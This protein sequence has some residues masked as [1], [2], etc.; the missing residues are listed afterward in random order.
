MSTQVAT[1]N[2]VGPYP[3][4]PVGAGS[5]DLTL[6]AVDSVN[7]NYFIADPV[8]VLPQGSIGGDTLLVYNPTAG[9]LVITFTS[10]PLNG[11]SGDIAAYSV[12]AGVLSAFKFSSFSGWALN[13]TNQVFFTGAAGLLVAIIQR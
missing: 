4:L 3:S 6:T 1:Q 5:L 9:A 10:Q 8:S 12:G 11:R 13:P 2:P 7:G